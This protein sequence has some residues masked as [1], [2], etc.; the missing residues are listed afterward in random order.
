LDVEA[1]DQIG[2]YLFGLVGMRGYAVE[3]LNVSD[4]H[5]PNVVY[6]LGS[7]TYESGFLLFFTMGRVFSLKFQQVV[8]YQLTL[9]I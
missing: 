4:L 1:L 2:I 7:V 5:L 6:V 3:I 8:F 9:L